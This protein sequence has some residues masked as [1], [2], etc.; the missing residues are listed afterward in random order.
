MA[1]VTLHTGSILMGLVAALFCLTL[2]GVTLIR[3]QAVFPWQ[4]KRARWDLLGRG[5]LLFGLGILVATV[6][7]M[8]DISAGWGLVV[9]GVAL[10]PWAVSCDFMVR[11]KLPRTH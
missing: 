11:A 4:R 6:P 8:A 9:T 5:Q 2:G 10:I 7:R 1:T 3:Q